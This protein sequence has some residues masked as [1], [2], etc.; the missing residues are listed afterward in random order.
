MTALILSAAVML[1]FLSEV[2][3]VL[4]GNTVVVDATQFK[5]VTGPLAVVDVNV[6]SAESASMLPN[7]TVLIRNKVIE[8]IG[9]DIQVPNNYRVIDGEGKYLIPGLIDS[10]VHIKKSKN[11]LLLYIANGV[12]HISEMTGMKGHFKY[13]KEI[14]AGGL[15]PDIYISSPKVTSQ[16]GLKPTL[17][18]WFEKRHQNFST[19]LEGQKAVTKFKSLGYDSIKISS[20]LSSEIYFAVAKEAQKQGMPVIGHLPIGLGMDDLY[21]SGQSQLA[22]IDSITMVTIKDFGGLTADNSEAYLQYLRENIDPIAVKLRENKVVVSSTIWLIES[23]LK[24]KFDLPNFLK[25]IEL[26]YQN[27]GWVE[28]SV[29]SRGWLPGNSSY[30]SPN[31]TDAQS[32][33]ETQNYWQTYIEAMHI[34]TRALARNG[35]TIMAGTDSNGADGVIAGFALHDELESLSKVGLSNLQVLDAATVAPAEWMGINSGKIKIGFEADLVLLDKNPLEDISN[36]R[37]INAVIANGN[38]LDRSQLDQ[39][40]EAVEAANNSSRKVSIDEY[41]TD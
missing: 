32:K 29:I 13:R 3:H 2:D 39:I 30:E 11:D 33:R 22:H 24:Q 40:L 26:K 14:E 16:K 19:P 12:T 38:Y 6:W 5:P 25:T 31:N 17:R 21:Q 27:P 4:G 1:F 35:V 41:L 8:S 23:I 18:S 28:G 9:R 20:D 37:S 15:G 34:T 36:T 10:H 7:Q